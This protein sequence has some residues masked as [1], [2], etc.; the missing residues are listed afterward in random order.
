MAIEK[1]IPVHSKTTSVLVADHDPHMLRLIARKL[2]SDG[3]HVL[4]VFKWQDVVDSIRAEVP[5]LVI[6]DIAMPKLNGLEA[7][8]RVREFSTVPIIVVT[9][10][11]QAH[12]KISSFEAG[13][14]DYITK[15]FNPE[16]LAA[17]VHAVLRRARCDAETCERPPSKITVGGLAVDYDQCLVTV[18]GRPVK[19][20]ATEFRILAYLAQN[21]GR[22]LTPDLLLEHVWS[23][24]CVGQMNLLKV[25]ISRLRRKIEP[26]PTHSVFIVTKNGIGYLM[27]TQPD[28]APLRTAAAATMPRLQKLG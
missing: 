20:T 22:V 19:L 13:A 24:T 18:D 2:E 10:L 6:L 14:D 9:T 3:Y 1:S 8:E 26:D 16:E 23:W 17:R 5:D 12:Y 25:N 28:K 4:R 27:P 21:A 15:P 7:C 11:A